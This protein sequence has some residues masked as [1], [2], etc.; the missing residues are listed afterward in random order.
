[1][2]KC[3]ISQALLPRLHR[4]GFLALAVL[5][6]SLPFSH[7]HPRVTHADPLGEHVHPSVIHSIFSPSENEDGLKPIPDASPAVASLG[8]LAEVFKTLD[9]WGIVSGEHVLQAP[10]KAG[11]KT[12]LFPAEIGSALRQ[13]ENARF[14]LPETDQNFSPKNWFAFPSPVR[15]PPALSL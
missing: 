11:A 5:V 14:S 8:D 4:T 15:P 9:E 1:M 7:V 3:V 13:V 2:M 10:S 6:L 12:G